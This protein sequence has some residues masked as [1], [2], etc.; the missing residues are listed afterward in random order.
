LNQVAGARSLQQAARFLIVGAVNSLVSGATFIWLSSRIDPALAYT[1]AFALG[2]VIALGATPRVVFGASA[3]AR[4][5][6][7]Y[8]GLYLAVYLVGLLAV[9]ILFRLM[10]LN[11]V[12][13]SVVV[14]LITA[15]TS[16]IGARLIFDRQPAGRPSAV[17]IDR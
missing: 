15:V 7:R 2:L 1:I 8:A 14:F 3:S 13:V 6:L 9:Q 10:G 4:Q 5:R 16:F 11:S 17:R 12:L